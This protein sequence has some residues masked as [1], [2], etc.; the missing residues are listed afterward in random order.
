[1]R[2]TSEMTVPEGWSKMTLG[3]I[4]RDGTT[5]L[6]PTQY[7]DERF[8]LY[9]IPA[10]ETCRPELVKGRDIGSTKKTLSPHTVLL[11]KINPRINRV[12]VV[13]DSGGLRQIGSSEW[14]AFCPIE[15]VVPQ[16]LAHYLRQDRCRTYLASNVSGVGGSLM[17]VKASVID[18]F[19]FALPSSRE[20]QRIVD[21]VDSYL[22]RLDDAIASLERVHAK[23]KAYR[24]SVLKAAVEGRLVS[25]EACLARVEERAYE[26][27]GVLLRRAETPVAQRK[28]RAGRLWGAGVVPALSDM[29][30]SNLPDGWCWAKVSELGPLPDEVVQVGPMSMRS[31]DFSDSGVTVLNVGCVQWGDLAPF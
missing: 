8:E 26:P 23:L 28:R 3:D 7:P 21:T 9:S 29:E 15:G 24:A 1:M 11:S 16:Y 14:I 18:P 20:Q 6:D 25:T 19:P 10:H 5:A 17:R 30:R 22:T 4:R 13:G 2:L 12:W 31:Q 27:A